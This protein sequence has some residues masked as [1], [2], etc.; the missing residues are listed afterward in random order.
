VDCPGVVYE[1]GDSESD[2]VLKGVVRVSNLADPV[3]YIP[4]VLERVKKEYIANTY[5]I[6]SWQ[7]H[8]DF[9][10]QFAKN[11]GKLLKVHYSSFS[12]FFFLLPSFLYALCCSLF[13]SIKTGRRAGPWNG[14]KNDSDGLAKRE[15]SL[16]RLSSI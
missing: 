2:I 1:S 9:L 11:S 4:A 5:N 15:N 3:E 8:I 14:G 10:S 6:S 7:D 13:G 12:F 16:F